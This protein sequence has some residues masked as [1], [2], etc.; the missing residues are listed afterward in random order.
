MFFFKVALHK[1]F[2]DCWAELWA[3][4]QWMGMFEHGDDR[5]NSAATL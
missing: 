1:I 5:D 4:G 3:D 2:P